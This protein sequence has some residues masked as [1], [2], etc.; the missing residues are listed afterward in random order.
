MLR[1]LSFFII[2]MLCLSGFMVSP[3]ALWAHGVVGQRFFVESE[4]VEDPFASDEMDLFDYSHQHDGE[5]QST[6]YGGGIS[7][8]LSPNLGFGM[9]W[10]YDVDNPKEE[11]AVRGWSNLAL[12]VKYTMVRIPEHEFIAS[13]MVDYDWGNTGAKKVREQ[14]STVTPTLLFGYGFGDL[15]DSLAYLKPFALTG[16]LGIGSPFR[17]PS[18]DGGEIENDLSYGLVLQYSLLYLQSFVKDIGLGW[19]FNRLV[20]IM[21]Y[22]VDMGFNGPDFGKKTGAY[23]PGIVWAGR[24]Y[25]VNVEGIV[26]INSQSGGYGA[27]ALIHLYLDDM[28]PKTYTWTP[29]YGVL[30]GTQR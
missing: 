4:S 25:Q 20:P 7:K 14:F 6:S 15:P 23:Y 29:F 5:G 9:E 30:G 3:T 19:P 1:R 13:A 21:E 26:P 11:S 16:S 8:R 10:E 22:S 2:L 27:Q 12:H 18:T 24:Y 28:F 17:N